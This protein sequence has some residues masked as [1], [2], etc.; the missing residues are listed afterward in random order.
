MSDAA[1]A[2]LRYVFGFDAFRGEQARIV[3]H[4]VAGGDALVL[5]PTGG[6]KSLC[7]Q[8]PAELAQRTDIVVSPLISLMKDQ[9]DGLR[10][11]GYPAAAL[12]STGTPRLISSQ[13]SPLTTAVS[14][15]GEALA[16]EIERCTGIQTRVTKLG[17]VQRGGSP[18]A[19]DR[20]LATRFGIKAYEMVRDSQWGQMVAVQGNKIVSVPLDQ[21]VSQLKRLDEDIYRVAEVFFG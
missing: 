9:V 13:P 3:D 12:L 17:Y 21:A 18:T 16:S 1:L 5:M 4:I 2:Q 8:V 10:E 14:T 20:I 6:G 11:C 15:S 7:Y 19:F